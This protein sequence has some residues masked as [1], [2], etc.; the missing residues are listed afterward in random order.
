MPFFGIGILLI[1]TWRENPAALSHAL[2]LS[3][4]TPPI[5]ASL[6]SSP[7]GKNSVRGDVNPANTAASVSMTA[8]PVVSGR[9]FNEA[10]GRANCK[11]ADKQYDA[12]SLNPNWE[13]S[14]GQK[15]GS[16]LLFKAQ[17]AS[18]MEL[19]LASSLVEIDQ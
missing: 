16:T 4:W 19:Y 3:V 18:W 17:W 9:T 12:K 11:N 2:K 1:S 14:K 5:V 7:S 6:L 8:K 10:S 13:S 15:T